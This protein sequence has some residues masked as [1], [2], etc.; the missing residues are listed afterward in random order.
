M[1][2]KLKNTILQVCPESGTF[3]NNKEDFYLYEKAAETAW[4]NIPSCCFEAFVESMPR[5]V[6][7]VIDAKG[8]FTKY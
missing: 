1:S 4:K 5:R 2:W 8:C 6:K 3:S 7:A